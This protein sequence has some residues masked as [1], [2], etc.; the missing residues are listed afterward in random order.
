MTG[1]SR[2]WPAGFSS[3][4]RKP[5]TLRH[6]VYETI[7]GRIAEDEGRFQP[8]GAAIRFNSFLFF[9]NVNYLEESVAEFNVGTAVIKE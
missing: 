3:K 9:A 7:E 8:K 5:Q 2:H 1:S 6:N 4:P